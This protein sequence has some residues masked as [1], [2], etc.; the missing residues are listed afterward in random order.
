VQQVLVAILSDDLLMCEGLSHIVAADTLL[1]LVGQLAAT[2]F[3][4]AVRAAGA[5]VLLVDS[6][7]PNALEV[8]AAVKREGGPAV[9]FFMAPRDDNTWAVD[10]LA[11]GARGVLAK[12]AR[13]QDLV[14]AIH[15][16]HDGQ[17]WARRQAI[18]AWV[19]HMA[20]R[21]PDDRISRLEQGLSDR[22]KEVFRHAATGLTNKELAQRLIISEA[23]VKV[24]LTHIFQKL[25][26]RGRAELAATY[27]D[28]IPPSPDRFPGSILRR[29]A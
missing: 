1:S 5:D 17:I 2:V 27:H 20:G 14:K 25:G 29:P 15:V 24:H 18:E 16:V 28:I 26:L 23:T 19:G 6:R 22:E 7:M 8:C 21:L 13:A 12:D 4:P 9:I 3:G 10:A 11:A